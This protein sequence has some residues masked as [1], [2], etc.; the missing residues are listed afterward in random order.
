[1]ISKKRAIHSYKT[2][3]TDAQAEFASPYELTK[4]LFTGALKSMALIPV[5]MERKEW[6]ECS[7]EMTRSVGILSGLRDSLDL[8]QGE[9][10]ENLYQL[11]S[12]MI[13]EMM[14]AYS[15]KDLAALRKVRSLLVE[16][17]DAWNQIP[18]EL[19]AVR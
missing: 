13:R 16:I 15:K 7:K 11:Y 5:L 19:R 12:Y 10:A 6:E 14:R 9:I 2:I 3:D 1:M 17:D 18:H 8:S 4:M